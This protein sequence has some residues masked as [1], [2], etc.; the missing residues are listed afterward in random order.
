V[1]GVVSFGPFRLIANERL[2]V[3]NG[4]PVAI[5]GRALDI[6]IALTDRAGQV[7][8]KRELMDVVWPNTR[9]D[10]ASLRVHL[11][12]LRR[13][14][15]DGEQGIRHIVNVSG[16]GYSFVAPVQYLD[17]HETVATSSSQSANFPPLVRLIGREGAINALSSLLLARRF[18]NVV[19]PGG[20]GKTSVAVALAHAAQLNFVGDRACFVDLGSLADAAHVLSAIASALRCSIQGADPELS[21]LAFLAGKRML[22]VL[23]SCE[24]VIDAVAPLAERLFHAAPSVY[25]LATSREALRVDGEYV[26]RLPP[27]DSPIDEHPSAIQAL[28]SPAVQLFLQRAV[29]NGYEEK[30]SDS[31]ART[32]A[33]ICR[34]LDGIP[35]A[36]ELAAS[37][38]TAFGIQGTADLMESGAAQHLQGRRSA[39]PRH[40]TLQAMLDWSFRLLSAHEQ[41]V[42]CKLSVFV[43]LFSLEAAQFVAGSGDSDMQ[44]I[45]HAIASLV[46][47]SLISSTQTSGGS[48]F[49]LLDTT[50]TYAAAKLT[51]SGGTEEAAQRHSRYFAD[52]LGS[53]IAE[54]SFDRET[55]AIHA[56]HVDNV[57][58]G[59]G[60]TFSSSGDASIGIELA[61]R[62]APL[63]L[64]LSLFSEC[65]QWCKR[66]L[67]VLNKRDYGTRRELELQEAVAISSMWAPESDHGISEAIDRG[68]QL[69]E[70]LHDEWRQMLFL[71]GLNL[72]LVSVGD[73]GG[74]LIAAQ[75]CLSVAERSDNIRGKVVA[76][77]MLGATYHF[78]ADQSA[79]IY[80]CERGFELE[81]DAGRVQLNLFG[82]DHRMRALVGLARSL[83]LRG[84][85]DQARKVAH[86]TI[87]E[88][89]RQGQPLSHIIALV[90]SIPV[91][92]WRGDFEEADA[93]IQ[94]SI[95]L[96]SRYP[97]STFHAIGVA[98]NGELMVENG[99]PISGV[100]SLRDA[101]KVLLAHRH[102]IVIPAVQCALAKGLTSCREFEEAVATI[103][104]A[105]ADAEE[106]GESFWIP[107]LLRV[108]AEVLLALPHPDFA[109]A[110]EALVRSIDA[111]RKQSA[112]SWELKAATPLA[113]IWSQRGRSTE[114]RLMLADVYQ[115]FTE[116]VATRDLVAAQQ[117]L[118]E[119]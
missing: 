100:K 24:H 84:L 65:R 48:Y 80:H 42:L 37:Q 26:Y 97:M 103:D 60:W 4:V 110:E 55:V 96:G 74:A 13:L 66:A 64:S 39:Q 12:S 63:L 59:L 62:A 35:F 10:E 2:L 116:G 99:N 8:T 50:R 18:V 47:K 85:P 108:R 38:V 43:G 5:G 90:F 1:S 68:L 61:L 93:P 49:R 71:V 15:R 9:V 79:A 52:L 27:L 86:Q 31:D 45:N 117:L 44:A 94:A 30:P 19:G 112:L 105:L 17:E 22:I 46:E 119:L 113:R 14:L 41:G 54:S 33:R 32:I 98:L 21:I 83:W 77:W 70:A 92:L 107:E 25:L 28:R 89:D 115:R 36:I 75:R 34:K 104:G 76:E 67:K 82:F 111:A 69:S 53:T 3:R 87:D 56:L 11:T 51:A 81:P 7:V 6:L 78:A 20:I 91:F 101:L 72:V 73:F 102:R 118:D 95:S 16:R 88:A 23:D 40:K 106:S 57:R 58:Q 109:S 29:A 114:A